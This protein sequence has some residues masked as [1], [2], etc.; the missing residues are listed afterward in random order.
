MTL[1]LC[2]NQEIIGF[3][4]D[5]KARL[6]L[7]RRKVGGKIRTGVSQAARVSNA[8]KEVWVR[9]AR[10]TSAGEVGKQLHCERQILSLWKFSGMKA[11]LMS[12]SRGPGCG[13]GTIRSL[14]VFF[15]GGNRK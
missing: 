4:R 10:R 8:W 3:E 14:V 7:Q 2:F 9:R 1:L 11:P 15:L 5:Q 12:S 6:G 13:Q